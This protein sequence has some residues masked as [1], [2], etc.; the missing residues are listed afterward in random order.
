MNYTL[1]EG[2][3]YYLNYAYKQIYQTHY[4]YIHDYT[5]GFLRKHEFL[6]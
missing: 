6:C 2:G 1:Y 4:G 3:L 5:I